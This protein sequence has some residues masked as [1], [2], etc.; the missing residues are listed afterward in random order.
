ML[1]GICSWSVEPRTESSSRL[2]LLWYRGR[3]SAGEKLDVEEDDVDLGGKGR[4]SVSRQRSLVYFHLDTGLC[5]ARYSKKIV[6][7]ALLLVCLQSATPPCRLVVRSPPP[8]SRTLSFSLSLS[9]SLSKS[10]S[11]VRSPLCPS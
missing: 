4:S 10:L 3:L 11:P 5:H 1:F 8:F 9:L 2:S 6:I 7:E